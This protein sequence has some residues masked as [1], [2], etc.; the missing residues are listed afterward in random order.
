MTTQ[1]NIPVYIIKWFINKTKLY[2]IEDI[3]KLGKYL[4]TIEKTKEKISFSS[5]YEF[6]Y[7]N[8]DANKVRPENIFKVIWYRIISQME[9][10]FPNIEIDIKFEASSNIDRELK[11]INATYKHD[12]YITISYKEI[13]DEI[14][15]CA[16]EYFEKKH[17]RII[18]HDKEIRSRVIID[19]YCVYKENDDMLSFMKNTIHKLL[20]MVCAV[21]KDAYTLSKILFFSEFKDTKKIKQKTSILNKILKYKKNYSFNFDDLFNSLE[22]INPET[23]EKFTKEE[24]LEYLIDKFDIEIKLDENNNCD[25]K[26]FGKIIMYLDINLSNNLNFYKNIY[27]TTMNLLFK[28]GMLISDY[29]IEINQRKNL[30]PKFIDSFLCKHFQNYKCKFTKQKV[31]ENLTS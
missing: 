12:I 15:D 18:D 21:Q 27:D 26:Y 29:V 20:F 23:E 2:K 16:I 22:L 19:N 7:Y 4:S 13:Y 11:D 6:S 3:K 1:N 5:D 17:N 14:Y 8:Y 10:Y 9:K 31:I 30:L 24:F 25:F 28:S